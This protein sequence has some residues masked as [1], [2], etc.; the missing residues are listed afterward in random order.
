MLQQLPESSIQ[1]DTDQ[2][3]KISRRRKV[4][5]SGFV[6]TLVS[7]FAFVVGE[8]VVRQ[9]LS[10]D[11]LGWYERSDDPI[12]FYKLKP[13]VSGL[14]N[15]FPRH[16]TAQGLRGTREYPPRPPA[17]SY[18]T[19][20]IGDSA[21]CGSL[22]GDDATAPAQ[23]ESMAANDARTIEAINLGVVGYNIRQIRE[24]YHQRS[25]EFAGVE[26][27]I[28]YHHVNDIYNAPWWRLAPYVTSE[29]RCTFDPPASPLR[30]VLRR[31]ALLQYL[32]HTTIVHDWVSAERRNP[33]GDEANPDSFADMCLRGYVDNESAAHRF[34]DELRLLAEAVHESGADFIVLWFPARH[35]ARSTS[36]V[37][38]RDRVA[39]WVADV[40]GTFLDVTDMFRDGDPATLYVDASHPTREGNHIIATAIHDHLEPHLYENPV[41]ASPFVGDGNTP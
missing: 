30:R 37:D 18:R 38:A 34:R 4:L 32:R 25:H 22:I 17:N 6:F 20:W 33:N 29:L 41:V 26:T 13:S 28:Y 24:V 36:Y 31:S 9:T 8:I 40:G 39:G 21:C 12:L 3:P 14:D 23:L 19:L 27:V 1:S 35:A 11:P 10:I 5:F 7:L 15:G 16:Q 2:R